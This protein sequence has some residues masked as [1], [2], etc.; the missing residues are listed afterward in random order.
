MLLFSSITSFWLCI[1]E[2]A[3]PFIP[4]SRPVIDW[5]NEKKESIIT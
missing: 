2:N 4:I 1:Y 3:I 5:I